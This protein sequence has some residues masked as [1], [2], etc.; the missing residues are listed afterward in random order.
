[1]LKQTSIDLAGLAKM[2]VFVALEV[3]LERKQPFDHLEALETD[4]L[5]KTHPSVGLV[6]G[7]TPEA[8]GEMQP[9]ALVQILARREASLV[10]VKNSVA[11]KT[12]AKNVAFVALAETQGLVVTETLPSAA[13]KS[14]A[15]MKETLKRPQPSAALNALA[16]MQALVSPR[17]LERREVSAALQALY[18]WEASAGLGVPLKMQPSDALRVPSKMQVSAVLKVLEKTQAYHTLGTMASDDLK[19]QVALQ[20]IMSSAVLKKLLSSAHHEALQDMELS[21]SLKSGLA[22]VFAGMQKYG[23]LPSLAEALAGMQ[24]SGAR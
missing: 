2:Q 23:A 4:V 10:Q 17:V 9:Y 11:P 14:L 18:K 13:Q 24:P 1:M 3:V 7:K 16:G 6:A 21:V 5:E 12:L 20:E 8:C 19:V 15:Q 22:E